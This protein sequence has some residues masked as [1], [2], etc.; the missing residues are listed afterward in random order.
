MSEFSGNLLQ[1]KSIPQKGDIA[2]IV[3]FDDDDPIVLGTYKEKEVVIKF[4]TNGGAFEVKDGKGKK[5]KLYCSK[6]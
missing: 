3:K 6:I 1:V 5:V 4:G 2:F